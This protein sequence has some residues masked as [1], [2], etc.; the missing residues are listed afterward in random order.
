MQVGLAVL[1]TIEKENCQ[2]NSLKVGTHLLERLVKLVDQYEIVGDVRGKGLMIGIEMVEDKESKTP[3][4]TEAVMD[5][6]D[7]TKEVGM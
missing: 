3:L 7:A 6:W 1:D 5:I 4:N 2:A